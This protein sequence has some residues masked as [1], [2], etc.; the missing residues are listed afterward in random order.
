MTGRGFNNSF[1]GMF[2]FDGDGEIDMLEQYAQIDFL[3]GGKG[4]PED[5]DLAYDYMMHSNNP[6]PFYAASL[7][8]GDDDD[9]DD[10]LEDS[11]DGDSD[12][13]D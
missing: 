4:N 1:D 5:M 10:D 8:A 6:D 3:S 7:A 13:D 11:Y 9:E 2:D 12:Y